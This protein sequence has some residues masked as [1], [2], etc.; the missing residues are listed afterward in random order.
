VVAPGRKACDWRGMTREREQPAPPYTVEEGSSTIEPMQFVVRD[1]G[2]GGQRLDVTE[3]SYEQIYRIGDTYTTKLFVDLCR[4]HGLLPYRHKR[5]HAGTI[6]VRAP[7]SEHN[8]LWASF[9]ELCRE[10]EARLYELTCSFVAKTL[11]PASRP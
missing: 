10:L 2:Q 1:D 6:S 3:G 5:Q 4:S 7:V 9:L 8:A 11:G